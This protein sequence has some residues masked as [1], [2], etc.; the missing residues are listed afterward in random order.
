MANII[1]K[2]ILAAQDGVLAGE[3]YLPLGSTDM[4]A[5]VSDIARQRPNVC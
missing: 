3:R 1:I 4:D 2:D 5:L